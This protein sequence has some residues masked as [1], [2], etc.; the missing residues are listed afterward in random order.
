MK[1]KTIISLTLALGLLLMGSAAYGYWNDRGPQGMNRGDGYGCR[2]ANTDRAAYNAKANAP[3]ARVA[4][5]CR[6][7]WQGKVKWN[8]DRRYDHEK[9]PGYRAFRFLGRCW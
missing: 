8:S 3:V 5:P 6:G 2:Y 9:R 1:R 4:M 7:Y